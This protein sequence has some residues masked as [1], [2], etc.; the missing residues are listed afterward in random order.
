VLRHAA[1][2]G[3]LPVIT[4]VGLS[5]PLL[6]SGSLVTEV[7]F[8]WPGMGRVTYEAILSKDLPMVLAS[9]FLAA[10]LV[11]VGNLAADVALA[12]ADPRIRLRREAKR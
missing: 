12:A 8:A 6:V 9:T 4:L 2:N 10:L 7:V 1:R 5:L 11:I 3:L